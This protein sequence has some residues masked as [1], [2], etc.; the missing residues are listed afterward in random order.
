VLL[1]VLFGQSNA[2]KE[3]KKIERGINSALNEVEC[4]RTLD[5]LRLMEG[6]AEEALAIRREAI[7]H[8]IQGLVE[9]IELTHPVFSRAAQPLPTTLGIL[10]AIHLA[11]V[12]IWKEQAR[13]NVVMAAHATALALVA[14]ASG[15]PVV[16]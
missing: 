16:G 3:W 15:L 11:T 7:F 10:G 4:L 9:V 8:L 1:R 14:K 5:R 12:L 2:L 6:L 13:E